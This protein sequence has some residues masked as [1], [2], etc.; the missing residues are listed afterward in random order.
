MAAAAAL[1]QDASKDRVPTFRT[2]VSV[3]RVDVKVSSPA[4]TSI[5]GLTRDDFVLFDEERRQQIL[6]VDR[7]SDPLDVVLLLD[8]SGSMY[9]A[10][11][12]LAR[13]VRQALGQL[14]PGD[15][16][17]L[18]LF[19]SRAAVVQPFTTDFSAIRAAMI[20]NI[21][22]QEM[23]S[24]TRL[25]EAVAEA[26]RQLEL[27]PSGRRRA[28][29]AVTDNRGE[30]ETLSAETILRRLSTTDSLMSAIV[31]GSS[32]AGGV[33]R[34]VEAT[35]GDTVQA[36]EIATVFG[37]IIGSL[38]TRYVLEYS[39]APGGA[40]GKFRR[41]RVALSEDAQKRHPGASVVSRSGYYVSQ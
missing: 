11:G 4:G 29:V 38:R 27:R 34:F 22:K 35:G 23:G 30:P 15:H 5:G 32:A 3:V 16:V 1:A 18:I 28:I 19:A 37:K 21:Y 14:R 33:R 24:G 8:V 31:L 25:N 13:T 7:Q 12:E 9:T 6:D 41:I 10:L 20:G 39:P 17:A 26:L 40:D 36:T 2:E